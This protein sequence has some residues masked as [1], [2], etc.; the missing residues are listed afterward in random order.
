ML[1]LD[2]LTNNKAAMLFLSVLAF[3]VAA[4]LVIIIFRMLFGSRLRMPGGRGRQARLGIVDA[5]DLDRQR[6]L[7]IV[8]RDNIEHLIMIGG[9]ND[10]V[11]E[12]EI[13]RAEAREL[14]DL[15]RDPAN[16]PPPDGRIPAPQAPP[17]PRVEE[18]ALPPLAEVGPTEPARGPTFPLP[19]RR[20]PPVPAQP[21]RRPPAP[22]KLPDSVTRGDEVPALQGQ[23]SAPAPAPP[24]PVLPPIPPL[25]APPAPPPAPP[26]FANASLPPPSPAAPPPNAPTPSAPLPGPSPR[27]PFLKP[28]PPRPPLRPLQ[29]TTPQPSQPIEPA[30]PP[31]PTAPGSGSDSAPQR[32]AGPLPPKVTRSLPPNA[33]TL[34]PPPSAPAQQ[35]P[36]TAPPPP[37]KD[38]LESLEEEMAKLLGRGS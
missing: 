13:V 38:A 10:L 29:R 19:P 12:S 34:R 11:I 22:P 37:S 20:P 17:L 9:P 28:L 8:R 23:P 7:I 21:E 25:A 16:A 15:R 1:S 3:L 30:P 6:Q 32:S 18:P 36:S 26:A 14:R 33:P 27:P 4:V 35:A 31:L 24:A 2:N 5:F